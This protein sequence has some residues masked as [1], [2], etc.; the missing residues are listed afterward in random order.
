MVVVRRQPPPLKQGAG[1]GAEMAALSR[2]S[3]EGG[4]GGGGTVKR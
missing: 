4:S 3:N 1:S 2:I